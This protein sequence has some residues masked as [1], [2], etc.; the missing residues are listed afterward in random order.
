MLFGRRRKVWKEAAFAHSVKT[1]N[2][3]HIHIL[4][5][6]VIGD[7]EEVMLEIIR[8]RGHTGEI[9]SP[10]TQVYSVEAQR[11]PDVVI[12]RCE[13]DSFSDPA[14]SAYLTYFDWC[15]AL[16]IPVI[17]SKHF[18][19]WA[20]DKF[21]SHLMVNKYLRVVGIQDTINPETSLCFD[22]EHATGLAAGYM[23]K[24]DAVVIK[25]PHSGRGIGVFLAAS[26][27]EVQEILGQAFG[28]QEP[29]MLQ[30]PIDKETNDRGGFKDFR[31]WACRNGTTDEIEFVEAYYRNGAQGEFT[32]N[33][34]HGGGIS[35][36]ESIDHELIFWVKHVMEALQ[37]DVA[38][39][40]FARDKQGRYWFLEVNVAFEALRHSALARFGNTVLE[41]TVDLAES[42]ARISEGISS[43]L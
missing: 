40:D 4:K 24:Y 13:L 8:Q 17:N 9:V 30:Q 42:K 14:L 10:F 19:L 36:T 15:H 22:R 34:S 1:M 33:G 2:R 31:V 21:A 23:E 16:G 35:A 7:A 25:K 38:G 18:L 28:A 6:A 32:T 39:I 20:Q 5:H 12:T 26:G 41:K 43:I 3:L 37:G 27:D 29:V 11:T